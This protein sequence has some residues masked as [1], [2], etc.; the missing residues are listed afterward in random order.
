MTISAQ[1]LTG[2][3]YSQNAARLSLLNLQRQ[4]ENILLAIEQYNGTIEYFL[5]ML[6][7]SE[8][9]IELYKTTQCKFGTSCKVDWCCRYHDQSEMRRRLDIPYSSM[10]CPTENCRT[11]DLQCHFSKNYFEM[12]TN[13]DRF[14]KSL[15]KERT[16]T[17][18]CAVK[19]QPCG[20]AHSGWLGY[21]TY[22]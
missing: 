1:L 9:D 16:V 22:D 11:V 13:P 5:R 19:S 3:V 20:N 4:E 21:S 10:P 14:L 6:L 7:R 2:G 18:I 12:V 15:C 8:I 17:G